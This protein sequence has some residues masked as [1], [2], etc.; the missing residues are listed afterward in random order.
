MFGV[1]AAIPLASFAAAL[2]LAGE[3]ALGLL[4]LGRI[5]DGLD[6]SAELPS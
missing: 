1:T 5:F 6:V 2:V 3:G 4:L